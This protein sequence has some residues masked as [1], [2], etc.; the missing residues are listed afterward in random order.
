MFLNAANN[1]FLLH[2][3]RMCMCTAMYSEQNMWLAVTFLF[4][5]FKVVFFHIIMI[6]IINML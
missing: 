6:F 3:P 2:W 4:K 5:D 1:L